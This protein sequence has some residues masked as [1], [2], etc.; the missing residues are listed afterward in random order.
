MVFGWGR[1]R[2][3]KEGVPASAP[4]EISLPEVPRILDDLMQRESGRLLEQARKLR[5]PITRH[6]ESLLKIAIELEKD[7]I[8][9]NDIDTNIVT[10]V[11]RGK[12]QVLDAIH[13]ESEREFPELDSVDDV[14]AFNRMASQTLAKIGDVLGKQTRV[15]HIFAKK[16]AGRLKEILEKFTQDLDHLN[17]LLKRFAEFEEGQSKVSELLSKLDSEQSAMADISEKILGLEGTVS[18][19]AK[20]IEYLE[21][22]ITKFKSST[23]YEKYRAICRQ[24]SDLESKR[25]QIESQINNQT[26]LISRPLSKYEYGSS[27]DKENKAIIEKLLSSP[28]EAFLPQNKDGIMTILENIKKAI[29]LD[30]LSVKEPEKTLGYIDDIISKVDG[31]IRTVDSFLSEQGKL[32]DELQGLDLDV[33]EGY[34]KRH[35]KL[36]E[37][38]SFSQSRIRDLRSEI[39][40]LKSNRPMLVGE[41]TSVMSR[42]GSTKYTV[43]ERS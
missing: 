25:S 41:I 39:D 10:I 23:K 32:R 27:L 36:K 18:E 38:N 5:F 37:D 9:T 28:F 2:E 12:K 16:Y 34:Q 33:L 42:L 3:K 31:F 29:T 24:M 22:K 35:S 15:I 6:I 19:N 26:I 43:G 1:K 17:R 8:N 11:R 40:T 4:R 20:S 21:A 13:K 30:H 14:K 7:R